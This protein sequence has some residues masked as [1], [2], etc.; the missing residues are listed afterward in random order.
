MS[1]YRSKDLNRPSWRAFTL[2]ELLVV[3]AII[4]V[5]LSILIPSLRLVRVRAYRTGCMHN[6]KQIGLGMSMYLDG[7][8]NIWPCAEDP[9]SSS[10]FYWL[11]MGRGWRAF[12]KPYLGGVIDVNNPS[13]LL[14]P[15]DRANPTMYE[16]TS[17]AYSMAFY[18]SPDQIDAMSDKADTYDKNR[19]KPSFPQRRDNVAYPAE[20]ILIGEWSSNHLSIDQE[21]GWWNWQGARNFLFADGQVTFLHAEEI[22]PARDGLP[23]VNLTI[24]GIKGRD[25]TP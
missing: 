19:I 18:H 23:D 6:L 9:V 20:K 24:R 16:S 17:Y 3:L 11:W 25:W 15:E 22:R 21:Q 4:G 1:V 12:V 2:I 8:D 14:C 5:L 7:N 13:V 10:P